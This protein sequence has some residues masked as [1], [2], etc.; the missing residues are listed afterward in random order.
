MP[1]WYEHAFRITTSL[2]KTP[3][4]QSFDDYFDKVLKLLNESHWHSCDVIRMANADVSIFDWPM[5]WCTINDD[6]A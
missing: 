3:V 4:I 6:F 2:Y 5:R 1:S